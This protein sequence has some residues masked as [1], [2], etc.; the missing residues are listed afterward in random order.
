MAGIALP[1][2]LAALKA[3]S[4]T[5]RAHV[6]TAEA[7]A[8][9]PAPVLDVLLEQRLFRLWL[10]RNAGGDELDLMD[11][12]ALMEA[13]AR[14]DGSF[15]W[16]VMIGSGGGLFGAIIEAPTA[17]EMLSPREAVIA[18]SGVPSGR[19]EAVEGGYRAAGR[20]RYA[21][22]AAHATWFT[23]NCVVHRDG[24]A[25]LDTAGAPLIRAMSFPAT[26]VAVHRT[27]DV[28]GMRATGSEDFS[29][30]GVFV[31]A[32]RTFSVFGDPPHEGGPL[33]RFP[34]VS[35][36]QAGV[37]AVALGV[38]AHAVEAYAALGRPA[39]ATAQAH[40]GEAVARLDLAGA[41]WWEVTRVAWERVVAGEAL[42]A[43]GQ[44]RV[45]LACTRATHEAAA[46]VDLLHAAGG[47]AAL[48]NSGGDRGD[49]GR[50]WRDLHAV[51]QHSSVRVANYA[52]AGAAL[53]DTG[54]ETETPRS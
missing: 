31:P 27:W 10:P 36:T 32:R 19:A 17:H 34:F 6:A 54:G 14:I 37:A 15:G 28:S 9:W 11:S 47:M 48:S 30:D 21:S 24:A 2:R 33:Y 45:A 49:L 41:G 22:G 3:A 20:W 26:E 42:D 53:L 43:A 50:C 25:V 5:V 4:A 13:S 29:V 23:A 40:Y 8:R 7:E 18:G 46:A 35:I 52:S 1:A 38:A 39:D 51:T 16:T 12:L 44:A